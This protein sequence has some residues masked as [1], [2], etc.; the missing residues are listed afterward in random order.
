MTLEY[1]TSTRRLRVEIITHPTQ[2]LLR[3]QLRLKN[4]R[5]DNF[6]EQSVDRTYTYRSDEHT[7]FTEIRAFR[8]HQSAERQRQAEDKTQYQTA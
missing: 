7:G 2:S 8:C 4:N 5:G 3:L 1:F 6:D